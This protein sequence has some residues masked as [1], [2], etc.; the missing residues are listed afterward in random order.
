MVIIGPPGTGKSQGGILPVVADS[1][2]I[3][4]DDLMHRGY[5]LILVDPQGELTP[6][7]LDYAGVTG[8]QVILRD[9]TDPGLPH[10]NLAQG[11]RNISDAESIAQVLLGSSI[12]H[13]PH[14]FW[15]NS[16]RNLMA[17]CLMRFDNLGDILLALSDIRALADV[18]SADERTQRLAAGFLNN[19]YQDGRRAGDIV[20]TM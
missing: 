15:E 3:G 4:H 10:Y 2:Y 19:A 11:I 12:S 7:I 16:A 20:A 14:G 1:M 9:P 6:Y 18:L 8:H 17:A 5:S 13:G